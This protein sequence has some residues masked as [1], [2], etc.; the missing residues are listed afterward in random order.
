VQSETASQYSAK[1]TGCNSADPS[2]L[3]P[4]WVHSYVANRR[5]RKSAIEMARHHTFAIN[6]VVHKGAG[7]AGQ[8]AQVDAGPSLASCRILCEHNPDD[9]AHSDAGKSCQALLSS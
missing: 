5:L 9:K 2:S 6:I 4:S 8:V 3:V 7:P 1:E